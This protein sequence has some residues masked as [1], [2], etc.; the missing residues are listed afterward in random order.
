[1]ITLARTA[2][3]FTQDLFIVYYKKKISGVL[4]PPSVVSR[5][6][7]WSKASTHNSIAREA[8]RKHDTA[9]RHCSE[10]V[11]CSI[12]SIYAAMC[13]MLWHHS[14]TCRQALRT[15]NWEKERGFN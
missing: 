15:S 7:S 10:S 5:V 2:Q 13:S 8:M 14:T 12:T 6:N 1:M 11:G 3:Q 9:S 4:L